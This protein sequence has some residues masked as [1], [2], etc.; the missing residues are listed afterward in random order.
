VT[1]LDNAPDMLATARR[2]HPA[3][4]WIEADLARDD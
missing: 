1:G 2:A 3:I 4:D